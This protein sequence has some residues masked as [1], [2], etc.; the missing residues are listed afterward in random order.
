[1]ESVCWARVEVGDK[2][3]YIDVSGQW[4]WVDDSEEWSARLTG[5]RE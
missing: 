3:D 2:S 1:M 4:V 5:K